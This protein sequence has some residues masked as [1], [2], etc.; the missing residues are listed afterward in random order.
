MAFLACKVA[1]NRV[2]VRV[3]N[4]FIPYL[5]FP[6]NWYRPEGRN[7]VFDAAAKLAEYEQNGTPD[8]GR[9]SDGEPAP[10]PITAQDVYRAAKKGKGREL[11][12]L[13]FVHDLDADTRMDAQ[14]ELV[15]RYVFNVTK[16]L[17]VVDVGAELQ[18]RK[19]YYRCLAS[20]IDQRNRLGR[21][22]KLVFISPEVKREIRDQLSYQNA[23]DVWERLVS[24]SRVAYDL[25][26]N[27][28]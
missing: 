19:S 21:F 8:G 24:V 12:F 14:A 25:L 16:T 13:I 28:Q 20:L 5:P 15:T 2:R 7:D 6:F 23:L 26:N 17:E 11:S 9:F 18:H 3:R 27:D 22:T 10:A 4:P 1:C